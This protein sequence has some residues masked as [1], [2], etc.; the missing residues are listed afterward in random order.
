ML[1]PI[2]PLL[3]VEFDV[4]YTALGM[5]IM[6]FNIVSLICQP[7]AGFLVDRIGASRLLIAGVALVPDFSMP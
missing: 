1:P 3:K 2:L 5:A 6:T 7:P 4:S